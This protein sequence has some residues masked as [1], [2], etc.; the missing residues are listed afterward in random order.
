M[1]CPHLFNIID[2]FF[3]EDGHIS[4]DAPAIRGKSM[5]EREVVQR[6]VNGGNAG[7]VGSCDEV[8]EIEAGGLAGC[9]W[10]LFLPSLGKGLL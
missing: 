6:G 7:V 5:F 9:A 2:A 3:L 8:G 10:V 1:D 4:D